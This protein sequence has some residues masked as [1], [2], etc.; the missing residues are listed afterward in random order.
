MCVWLFRLFLGHRLV[1]TFHYSGLHGAESKQICAKIL[2]LANYAICAD[3]DLALILI[4]FLHKSGFYME[5]WF[6]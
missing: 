5:F 6:V 2:L 4:T 1:L 3:N